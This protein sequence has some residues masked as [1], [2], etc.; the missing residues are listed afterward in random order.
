MESPKYWIDWLGRLWKGPC[1]PDST[2]HYAVFCGYMVKEPFDP[3][4]VLYRTD[5]PE[6]AD[7]VSHEQALRAAALFWR[8][9]GS[10]RLE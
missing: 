8:E 1:S 7:I 4:W 3:V 2:L 6:C 10:P 9:P 5:P